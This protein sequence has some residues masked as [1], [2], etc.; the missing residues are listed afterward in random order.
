MAYVVSAKW[1]AEEGQGAAAQPAPPPAA[2]A[3]AAANA[4]NPSCGPVIARW[5]RI[6]DTVSRVGS[7]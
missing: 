1:R 3:T 5:V 2:S 4:P 7:T 6:T